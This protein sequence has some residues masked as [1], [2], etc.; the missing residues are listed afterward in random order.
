[1]AAVRAERMCPQAVFLPPDFVRYKA[2]SQ[3]VREIFRRHTDIVD[4]CPS[5]THF[6]VTK[7]KMDLPTATRVAKMIREQ[8][9]EELDL[10]ASA[11]VA[12]NKFLAKIASDWRKPNGLFVIQPHEI[13][14]FLLLLPIGR[15]PG[16]GQVTGARLCRISASSPLAIST[17]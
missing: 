9:R 15:I 8:I 1:M 2:A 11:G 10:T 5:T 14:S 6:D 12:P 16:V 3:S 7:N 17:P 4:L 13:R